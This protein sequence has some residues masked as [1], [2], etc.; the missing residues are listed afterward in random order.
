MYSAICPLAIAPT[1]A[2]TFESDPKKENYQT[3]QDTISLNSS[4][5]KKN[6]N[7]GFPKNKNKK[8]CFTS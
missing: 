3:I 7:K 4:S 6:K 1:M 2:P 8:H 5:K